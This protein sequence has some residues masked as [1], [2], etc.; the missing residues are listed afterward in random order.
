MQR[1]QSLILS[2]ALS[3]WLR[4]SSDQAEPVGLHGTSNRDVLEARQ[5]AWLLPF[6]VSKGVCLAPTDLKSFPFKMTK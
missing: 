6:E 1:K 2:A 5:L 3:I 4:L